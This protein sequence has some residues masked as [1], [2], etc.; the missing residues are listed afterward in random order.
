MVDRTD[1]YRKI[2]FLD[3]KSQRDSLVRTAIKVKRLLDKFFTYSGNPRNMDDPRYN[4]KFLVFS[5]L[6]ILQTRRLSDSVLRYF[7]SPK[8]IPPYVRNENETENGK[9]S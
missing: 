7:Q 2:E 9:K 8:N 1:R 5:K 6:I 4:D 3:R